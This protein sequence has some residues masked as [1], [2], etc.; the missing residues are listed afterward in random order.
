MR[1]SQSFIPPHRYSQGC[2]YGIAILIPLRPRTCVFAVCGWPPVAMPSTPG[3]SCL[4]EYVS[5][6][7]TK[8]TTHQQDVTPLF[9]P[10]RRVSI[11]WAAWGNTGGARSLKKRA[12]S[13]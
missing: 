2:V 13:P 4:T 3:A 8:P 11:E 12:W 6:G 7:S 9:R 5:S 10:K 1:S